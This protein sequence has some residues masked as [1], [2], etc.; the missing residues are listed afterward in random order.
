[1]TPL[2]IIAALLPFALVG[3]ASVVVAAWKVRQQL[4]LTKLRAHPLALRRQPPNAQGMLD[5][6][7]AEC[8]SCTTPMV[9]VCRNPFTPKGKAYQ[10]P[11]TEH[12]KCENGHTWFGPNQTA[13][14][15]H[16]IQV[17]EGL[18]VVDPNADTRE[19]PSPPTNALSTED[20]LR[21]KAALLSAEIDKTKP[22]P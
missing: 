12:F 7:P 8:P 20:K 9:M 16:R 21:V 11:A 10:L 5:E 3:F 17:R 22:A 14:L 1:M 2:V 13:T 4:K 18:K 19:L 6:H 15:N